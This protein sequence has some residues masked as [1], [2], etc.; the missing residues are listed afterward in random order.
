MEGI[1][2]PITE[3]VRVLGVVVVPYI[4]VVAALAFDFMRRHGWRLWS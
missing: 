4:V 2:R 1:V 3:A